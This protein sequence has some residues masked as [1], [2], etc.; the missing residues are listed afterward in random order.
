MKLGVLFAVALMVI[1]LAAQNP[2]ES[3]KSQWV[4]VVALPPLKVTGAG[5]SKTVLQFRVKPTMHINSHTPH[6]DLL[7]PT[8]LDLPTDK[9]LKLNPVYP[10][11]HDITLPFDKTEKLNVYTGDFSVEVDAAALKSAAA[12]KSTV[13]AVLHYQAC[14]DSSCFP[15]KSLKFDLEV[16]VAR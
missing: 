4:D 15:P 13:P 12:G 7:I 1:G 14:N 2:L 3:G 9:G 8:T 5:S 10:S 16:N 11:G 6:S